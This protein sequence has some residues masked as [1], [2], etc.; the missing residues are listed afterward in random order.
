MDN[1][2][3]VAPQ[4]YA[5][6]AEPWPAHPMPD[7]DEGTEGLKRILASIKRFKWLIVL[8]MVVGAGVGTL[9]YRSA[10]V[11][12]QVRGAIWVSRDNAS[13][14]GGPVRQAELLQAQAWVELMRTGAV[15]D[16]V[17]LAERLYV[18]TGARNE[19][20]LS[21][22]ELGDRFAPGDYR[23]KVGAR[24][25]SL[26]LSTPAG[27]EI[28]R[29]GV[30]D[31]VGTG[32]GFR[33]VPTRAELVPD[34]E[35]DFTV[36]NPR[37]AS[38]RLAD[39][40][41]ASMDRGNNFIRLSLTGRNP[42]KIASIL[43]RVMERMVLVAADLKR[44]QLEEESEALRDQLADVSAALERAENELEG[45]KI[46]TVTLPT[47]ESGPVAAGL[48]Q[49]RGPVFSDFFNRRIELDAVRQDRERLE[50]LLE[51]TGQ[52]IRVEA[53]ELV[54]AVQSSSQLRQALTELVQARAARR[55]LLQ[56]YTEEYGPVQ[57]L[58]QQIRQMEERDIPALTRSLVAN[59]HTQERQLQGVLDSRSAE[60][61]QIPSRVI[62]EARLQRARQTAEALYLDVN[63]RLETAQLASASSV[64]DIRIMDDARAPQAPFRDDRVRLFALA[65]AACL[66]LGLAAAVL[67]DRM[68]P[69]LR[70]PTDVANI[71][72][73]EVLGAVPRIEARKK[74]N[75][76]VVLEAFREIRMR[77]QYAYGSARPMV[78]SVTSSE[79][80]EGKTF[81]T[82]NLAITFAH[83]GRKTLVI[84][85]D[86]RRGDMHDLFE[87]DR[88]PGLT[89]LFRRTVDGSAIQ[90]TAHENLHFLPCGSRFTDSPD[91]LSTN[92]MQELLSAAK[93][94]YDVILIDSPPMAAGSDAFILGAHA[95][96]VLI[97]LRSGSTH[98]ELARA[99]LEAFYRL[100][101]RLLGAVL[102]DIE[103]G[104]AYGAY[105]YY[106]YY[107]PGYSAEEE[108]PEEES[109]AVAL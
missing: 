42:E 5:P 8:S 37:E 90:E 24:G 89:D 62:A 78:M 77:V 55:G 63:R 75:A 20:V 33:W 49:T 56:T 23:L 41:G 45:F 31:S 58:T 67:L 95:G 7:D 53:Y 71:M 6:V 93:R 76:E 107:L 43:Q 104:S 48:E 65:F 60:M 80:G 28:E 85:A 10:Q 36:L 32:L 83:L 44:Y 74:R 82:A 14:G 79:S 18:S 25:D 69:R 50:E 38:F 94:R 2:G 64:P 34:R 46:R 39:R 54:P 96:S 86:T 4:G 81:V 35:I 109:T 88:K 21:G 40:I 22:F 19:A 92:D 91:M 99:K 52:G 15:L 26:T 61:S 102:N 84:D 17:V 70:Y 97:V 66:G 1:G 30:G 87:M 98:K 9:A 11:E 73:L 12:Y 47:E 3:P 105:R 103:P 59:L 108:A 68:D 100:P 57:E 16:E 51:Q 29:V 13:A 106:S 72:G 101:V 27:V